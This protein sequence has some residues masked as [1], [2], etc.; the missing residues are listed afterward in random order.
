MSLIPQ[1]TEGN[2][3]VKMKRT[4]IDSITGSYQAVLREYD[5][6]VSPNRYPYGGA[7]ECSVYKNKKEN[8]TDLEFSIGSALDYARLAAD[9]LQRAA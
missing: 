3:V 2:V 5:I 7:Y 1:T 4:Q 6:S 9:A 8:E